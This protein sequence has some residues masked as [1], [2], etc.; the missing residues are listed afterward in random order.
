MATEAA[1][2]SATT[3]PQWR[4]RS[5]RARLLVG[6]A[7][8]ALLVAVLG[9]ASRDG[10]LASRAPAPAGLAV[11]KMRT[12]RG[13]TLQSAPWSEPVSAEDMASSDF[14]ID[15]ALDAP[16]QVPVS[17]PSVVAASEY[18]F[19]RMNQDRYMCEQPAFTFYS[20]LSAQVQLLDDDER[21]F[22]RLSVDGD[23]LPFDVVLRS[24]PAFDHE[25]TTSTARAGDV[26]Q[27]MGDYRME[28]LSPSACINGT[29]V[30]E[31]VEWPDE[32]SVIPADVVSRRGG[33]GS[34]GAAQ[35]PLAGPDDIA[36]PTAKTA[37]ATLAHKPST[38]PL[39]RASGI[40]WPSKASTTPAS[41][42]ELAQ[43]S[44]PLGYKPPTKEQM[45][46][47]KAQTTQL[48][49]GTL[50]AFYNAA[51]RYRDCKAFSVKDQ[52]SC[53][54]CYAFAAAGAL[55]AR[56]CAKS[57][58]QFNVDISPQQMVSC[59]G[60]DGCSGGNA[61]ETYEQMYTTGRV[62][63]W[64]L[65]YKGLD[66]DRGGPKCDAGACPNGME[67]MV[68]KDSLGVVADNVAAMQAEILINGPVF[69]AF[70]VYSD[71]MAYKGGVYTLSD[72]AKKEG[73]TGG[74]AVMLVGWGT[75]AAEGD[76]WLLQNSWSDKWGEDGYFKIRRG[77]DECSIESMGIWFA[78]P[79]LPK[80]CGA[81]ACANGSELDKDCKC[82]CDGGWT[83]DTC[84]VCTTTCGAGGKLN[85][86]DCSCVCLPGFTGETCD[87]K[88]RVE[89]A[90]VCADQFA[91]EA[92]P[93][94][95][96]S[97]ADEGRR[98][99][100]GGYIQVFAKGTEPWT[101]EGGWAQAATDPVHICGS[102]DE[103]KSGLKCAAAGELGV[104]QLVAGEY[105]VY[106]AKYL[107]SNEFGVSRGYAQPL[108]RLWP[109]LTVVEECDAV[110]AAQVDFKKKLRAASRI[111]LDRKL[112]ED[113]NAE[114]V[115]EAHIREAEAAAKTIKAPEPARLQS[116]SVAFGT[117]SIEY[118]L[119]AHADEDPPCTKEFGLFPAGQRDSWFKLGEVQG[120]RQGVLNLDVEGIPPGDY[121]I[122]ARFPF[123]PP[124]PPSGAPTCVRACICAAALLCCLLVGLS[125][126]RLSCTLP[127]Q[128]AGLTPPAIMCDVIP[129]L[130]SDAT[131]HSHGSD[132]QHPNSQGDDG[133]RGGTFVQIQVQHRRRA[134]RRDLGYPTARRRLAHHVGWPLQRGRPAHR[135][136][137][138]HLTLHSRR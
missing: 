4:E 86:R 18:V 72:A 34:S 83:G 39:A 80:A 106:Y 129:L 109:D 95:G 56:M 38:Q 50:P 112:E 100:P 52:K 3:A 16:G 27:L 99:V 32:E 85:P 29:S 30:L 31:D 28:S 134:S 7:G 51:E 15:A 53:G 79:K 88:V 94:V 124:A 70:W 108:E 131:T 68:E 92:W 44:R 73:P 121:D 82:R 42:S 107:G 62:S 113:R 128:Q 45:L 10:R 24:L 40:G 61:I 47:V 97:I 26:P 77:T 75:D 48:S 98:F 84:D 116:P 12:T 126:C 66:I 1:G 14:D 91:T 2:I 8:V 123:P 49:V 133:G 36:W 89:G 118:S 20:V 23:Q 63:E 138:T 5:P 57:G 6:V 125:P 104:P 135:G 96:W 130:T 22:L 58:G 13:T 132:G 117:V 46:K 76:Y 101:E 54:A 137:P 19:A 33:A 110:E 71:F 64:C 37:P 119:P 127:L 103:W 81:K 78:T 111:A 120:Q 21:F 136:M 9:L 60:D 43:F 59:N 41:L 115:R 69:A 87:S 122:G 11:S 67:Y 93:Y 90:V 65:P 25:I 55:S 17:D 105:S 35:N 114:V 74:H 102:K